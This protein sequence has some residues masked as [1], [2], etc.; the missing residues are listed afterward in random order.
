MANSKNNLTKSVVG[1][2][3][4]EIKL[5]RGQFETLDTQHEQNPNYPSAL[6][7]A[8]SLLYR[9]HDLGV[10]I[11]EEPF[12]NA[13]SI[14]DYIT[15]QL[16]SLRP[17]KSSRE[18]FHNLEETLK[19]HRIKEKQQIGRSLEIGDCA[20]SQPK[21]RECGLAAGYESRN[22]K[23]AFLKMISQAGKIDESDQPLLGGKRY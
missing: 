7:Y 22:Q 17:G 13:Y 11:P 4:L 16:S 15:S 2:F 10:P 20:L 1:A 18:I 23:K 12:S 19:T 5:S 21:V 9:S 14:H 3:L 8:R 6:E